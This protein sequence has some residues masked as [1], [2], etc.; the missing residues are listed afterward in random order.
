MRFLLSLLLFFPSI[1]AAQEITHINAD[2]TGDG[3]PDRAILALDAERD[4]ADLL[5]YVPNSDG[6][7][8]L[9]AEAKSVVWVGGIGQQPELSVTPHGSL[10]VISM[11]ESIGRNRWHQT[12]TIA[13]RN[14][15][16]VLAGYT[17]EWYDTLNVSENGKCDVNL[18]TGKGEISWGEE[19]E[20]KS[21][22]RTKSRGSPIDMWDREPP[23]ECFPDN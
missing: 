23:T 21:T 13:W 2:L 6:Q 10:Q 17:Y 14:D 18:L 15:M 3:V 16:F 7:F 4:D 9:R 5:I 19:F 22:F 8:A 1:I 11:N 20:N 12:L